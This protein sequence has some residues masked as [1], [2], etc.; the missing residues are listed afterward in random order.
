M[1]FQKGCLRKFPLNSDVTASLFKTEK[2]KRDNALNAANF[3]LNETF[4]KLLGLIKLPIQIAW[5]FPSLFLI[6]YDNNNNTDTN[7]YNIL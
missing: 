5:N 2:N 1:N 4:T 6:K 3:Q 7:N